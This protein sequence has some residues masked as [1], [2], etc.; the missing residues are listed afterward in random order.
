MG[1]VEWCEE[2]GHI[3]GMGCKRHMGWG[4]KS[5]RNVGHIMGMGCKGH[6]GREGRA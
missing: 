4:R 2:C 3:M 5:M 1:P 6:M